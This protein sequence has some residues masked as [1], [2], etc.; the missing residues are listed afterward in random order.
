MFAIPVVCLLGWGTGHTFSLDMDPLLIVILALAVVHT[1]G[2]QT[3]TVP[4]VVS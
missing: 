1:C 2:S 3:L 4:A